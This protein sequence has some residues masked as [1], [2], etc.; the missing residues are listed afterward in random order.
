[1]SSTISEKYINQF[2]R[3]KPYEKIAEMKYNMV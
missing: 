1:M 3:N 2:V